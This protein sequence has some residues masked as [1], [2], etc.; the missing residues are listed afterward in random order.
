MFDKSNSDIPFDFLLNV[1]IGV[2]VS[3]T[4]VCLAPAPRDGDLRGCGW[5][6]QPWSCSDQRS[7]PMHKKTKASDAANGG[8]EQPVTNSINASL[9]SQISVVIG[10]LL[11]NDGASLDELITATG[12]L[13][14]TTRAA[15]T[16][17][18]KKGHGIE[19][20]PSEGITRW[21]IAPSVPDLKKDSDADGESDDA[22]N[23]ASETKADENVPA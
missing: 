18:R 11:R 16:G 7:H 3:R 4:V 9:P 17:L 23:S 1:S 20:F 10:L 5:W 21:R 12:W 22:A 19:R 14:H 15:L 2:G 13:P 8:G 6:E